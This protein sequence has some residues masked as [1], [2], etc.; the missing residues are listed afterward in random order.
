MHI[1]ENNERARDIDLRRKETPKTAETT[2]AE[3]SSDVR[4]SSPRARP[5]EMVHNHCC[6]CATSPTAAA[7]RPPWPC[8]SIT[9]RSAPRPDERSPSPNRPP[10][11]EDAPPPLEPGLSSA[12]RAAR[13]AC[14]GAR[15]SRGNAST[16]DQPAGASRAGPSSSLGKRRVWWTCGAR[17]A[18]AALA[19]C[20]LWA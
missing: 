16:G 6:S 1:K 10:G 19:S 2:R 4:N 12:C 7:R 3:F 18:R 8:P 17:V 20:C 14:P 5:S 15:Q 9:P 13:D 11:P